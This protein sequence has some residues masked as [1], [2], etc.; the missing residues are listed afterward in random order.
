MRPHPRHAMLTAAFLLAGVI[1]AGCTGPTPAP[2]SSA[3]MYTCCA[4]NLG[5]TTWHAGQQVRITWTRQG[6]PAL[7]ASSTTLTVVLTGP[8]R[9]VT[10]LKD[11]NKAGPDRSRL[12]ATAP[13]IRTTA[14]SPTSSITIPR[15]AD[16][17]YYNLSTS[18]GAVG[19]SVS[20][21]M[22]IRVG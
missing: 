17:G 16:P 9:T 10:A 6:R 1:T 20:G 4:A 8:Y 5:A 21:A 19:I 2:H 11:A 3:V 12:V 14:T 13:V 7:G 18:S 22:V 15:S